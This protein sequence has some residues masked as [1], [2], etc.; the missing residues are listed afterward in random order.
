MQVLS[1]N[2]YNAQL[3]CDYKK[4]LLCENLIHPNRSFYLELTWSGRASTS[5]EFADKLFIQV[6]S[7]FSLL[8]VGLYFSKLCQVQGSNFFCLFNLLLICLDLIL[9]LVDQFL[10]S[11]VVFVIFLLLESQILDTSINS[12]LILLPIHKT[13]LLFIQLAF[14]F[15]KALFKTLNNFSSSFHCQLFSFI[16]FGLHILNLVFK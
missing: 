2:M 13:T 4:I 10:P 15:T 5:F 6:S 9:E 7:F 16:Q 3:Q 1:I 8:Q 11:F 14:K 12:A